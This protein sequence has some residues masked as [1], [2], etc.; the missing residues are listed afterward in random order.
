MSE[1]RGLSEMLLE[2]I[3]DVGE[4]GGDRSSTDPPNSL[5]NLGEPDRC[6]LEAR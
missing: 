6:C 4:L 1:V 5:S 2:D 3:C